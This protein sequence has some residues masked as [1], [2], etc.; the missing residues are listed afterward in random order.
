MTGRERV[1][2]RAGTFNVVEAGYG[3]GEKRFTKRFV[4]YGPRVAGALPILD[5]GRLVLVR[6]YRYPIGRWIYGLPGGKVGKGE[7][8]IDGARRELRE[9]TGY[10]AKRMRLI[11][12]TYAAPGLLRQS[13][14]SIYI[15]TG[16]TQDTRMLEL[17]EDIEVKRITLK[18]AL[19]W[20][21]EG[22]IRDLGTI[23]AILRYSGH[24][25]P[26]YDSL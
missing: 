1:L 23:A 25:R 10:R 4:D 6:Q 15:A 11:M 26:R 13:P 14:W 20:I 18:N 16:L 9:E 22:R 5:D 24:S 7:S 17:D 3:R 12:R 2:F 21:Y 8:M 19:S